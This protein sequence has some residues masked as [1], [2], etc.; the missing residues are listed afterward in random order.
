M[1]LLI[2]SVRSSVAIYSVRSGRKSIFPIMSDSKLFNDDS[3]DELTPE[4]DFSDCNSDV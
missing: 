4:L 3:G 2:V 1:C